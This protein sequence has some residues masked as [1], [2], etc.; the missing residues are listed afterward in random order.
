MSR[1]VNLE[2]DHESEESNDSATG[3]DEGWYFAQAGAAFSNGSFEQALRLFSK[4]LEFNPQNAPAW[5]GQVRMLI[6]MGEFQEAR[7]WAD[8]ALE[9]FPREGE[10]LAAKAVALA[11]L[12]DLKGAIAFSDASFEERGDSPYLWLAR[13][14]VLLARDDKPADYCL[15]KAIAL[16]PTDWFLHWLVSRIQFFYKKFSLALKSAQRSLSLNA[17]QSAVWLQA[18]YCQLAVGFVDQ[19]RHSF[20]QARELSPHS[21]E[22]QKALIEVSSMSLSRKL[23]NSVRRL[24]SRT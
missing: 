5:T 23:G 3:K 11:R 1:F 4:V 10:L 15:Q 17:G 14:D 16:A 6:E 2:F 13:G 9:R 12:G 18:G 22:A 8:K 19:A 7:V 24:F 20:V 21:V